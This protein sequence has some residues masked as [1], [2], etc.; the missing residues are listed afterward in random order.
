MHT[1][2]NVSAFVFRID[3]AKVA[4]AR[5]YWTKCKV[6]IDNSGFLTELVKVITLVHT[7]LDFNAGGLVCVLLQHQSNRR[8][9]VAVDKGSVDTFP[10]TLDSSD[11]KVI[12]VAERTLTAQT[13]CT[14]KVI[15]GCFGTFKVS[16][17]DLSDLFSRKT[18]AVISDAEVGLQCVRQV[19]V[20]GSVSFVS[21][22]MAVHSV[23]RQFSDDSTDLVG[24]QAR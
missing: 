2:N 6:C 19:N 22:R 21:C 8:H 5:N 18:C 10:A 3:K 11:S 9:T 20:K 12:G 13:Q 17:I 1:R 4:I 16:G 14:D 24:I 15:A 7:E 23:A